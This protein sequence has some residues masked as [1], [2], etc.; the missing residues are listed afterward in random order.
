MM[1]RPLQK[2]HSGRLSSGR[3]GIANRKHEKRSG[4]FP[5]A[6]ARLLL[7]SFVMVV[8]ELGHAVSMST[9]LEGAARD[10]SAYTPGAIATAST[11]PPTPTGVTVILQ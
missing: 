11:M 1:L 9:D 3:S 5:R 7:C 6:L 8:P 4:R 10:T 2:C